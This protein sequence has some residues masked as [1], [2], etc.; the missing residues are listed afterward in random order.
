MGASVVSRAG[1]EVQGR[2]V[3]ERVLSRSITPRTRR[4]FQ[5]FVGDGLDKGNFFGLLALSDDV[6]HGND[7][8]Y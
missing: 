4:S 5:S 2:A 6:T 8:Y 3:K 7:P 1:T